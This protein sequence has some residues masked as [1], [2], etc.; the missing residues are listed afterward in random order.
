[1]D[2]GLTEFF[3]GSVSQKVF[4]T[5]E[6]LSVLLVEYYNRRKKWILKMW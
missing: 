2:E 6:E 1:M 4:Q 5:V 3:L